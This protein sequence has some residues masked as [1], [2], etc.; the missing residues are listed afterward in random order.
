MRFTIVGF[1]LGRDG[2]NVPPVALAWLAGV[3][4]I[5]WPL[6]ALLLRLRYKISSN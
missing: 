5:D 3:G 4:S 1:T 6:P 2:G